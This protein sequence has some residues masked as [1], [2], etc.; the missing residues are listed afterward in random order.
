MGVQGVGW[1]VLEVHSFGFKY[2]S[3][4]CLDPGARVSLG[5]FTLNQPKNSQTRGLELVFYNQLIKKTITPKEQLFEL[6]LF[7]PTTIPFFSHLGYIGSSLFSSLAIDLLHRSAAALIRHIYCHS[8]PC[9][10]TRLQL[11]LV[12]GQSRL[13]T[14]SNLQPSQ[15]IQTWPKLEIVICFIPF[16]C[17]STLHSFVHNKYIYN[18][19]IGRGAILR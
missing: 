13:Q 10:Q 15:S 3:D 4:S 11:E 1:L 9:I 2:G 16:L 7:R 6:V 18:I 8:N 19:H 5:Q 17:R 14:N 12:Q